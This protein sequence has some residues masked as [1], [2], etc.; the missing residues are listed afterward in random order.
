MCTPYPCPVI[1]HFHPCLY[2]G[3]YSHIKTTYPNMPDYPHL[4]C[5]DTPARSL[6]SLNNLL[7]RPP[8]P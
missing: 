3:E 5:H 4:P 8:T 1:F 7:I 2:T 6:K